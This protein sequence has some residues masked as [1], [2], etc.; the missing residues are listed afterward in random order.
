MKIIEAEKVSA[1][2]K[3]GTIVEVAKDSF[4]IKCSDGGVKV[5]KIKP[6]GKN[7]MLVKDYFNG[8]KKE[9]LF[10]KEVL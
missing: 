5:T 6:F 4:T 3:V 9:S 7:V 1:K 8:V 10:S 2:G